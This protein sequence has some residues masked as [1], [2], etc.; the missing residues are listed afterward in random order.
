MAE[1]FNLNEA[2]RDTDLIGKRIEVIFPIDGSKWVG[3]IKSL[4]GCGLH[5][6]SDDGQLGCSISWLQV[7]LLDWKTKIT[8]GGAFR[9]MPNCWINFKGM[10]KVNFS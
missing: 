10:E 6:V 8:V 1:L 7:M 4:D 2:Q 5:W 9:W 3:T